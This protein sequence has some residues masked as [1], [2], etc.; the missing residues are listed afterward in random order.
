[1]ADGDWKPVLTVWSL[2]PPLP[3]GGASSGG[4]FQTSFHMPD[5]D[6]LKGRQQYPPPLMR[7]F[8]GN[9]GEWISAR[10]EPDCYSI[11]VR[12]VVGFSFSPRVDSQSPARGNGWPGCAPLS[13]WTLPVQAGLMYDKV[14][15]GPYVDDRPADF[16]PPDAPRPDTVNAYARLCAIADWPAS[17]VRLTMESRPPTDPTK[18]DAFLNW[19]S[20]AWW[21]QYRFPFRV[22]L[23]GD[24]L[25]Q[26][27][28][29]EGGRIDPRLAEGLSSLTAPRPDGALSWKDPQSVAESR[30][31]GRR[32]MP[33]LCG[34]LAPSYRPNEEF[35]SGVNL[36]ESFAINAA[37][38]SA[39]SGL[40]EPSSLKANRPGDYDR[41]G[42]A[43]ALAD[44]FW[45]A[46]NVRKGQLDD[47]DIAKPPTGDGEPNLDLDR[48][49]KSLPAMPDYPLSPA[50]R[51]VL[52]ALTSLN[53]ASANAAAEQTP[54]APAMP[55]LALFGW[56]GAAVA[57][58]ASKAALGNQQ[59]PYHYL[60]TRSFPAG[61][62]IGLEWRR[63]VSLLAPPGAV[64]GQAAA[65]V[66]MRVRQGDG[67]AEVSPNSA[68]ATYTVWIEGLTDAHA[69]HLWSRLVAGPL[70][71]QVTQ[72]QGRYGNCFLPDV[73]GQI[74]DAEAAAGGCWA[75]KLSC[76]ETLQAQE[77]GPSQAQ[78]ALPRD[79]VRRAVLFKSAL[80]PSQAAAGARPDW[81]I[82]SEPPGPGQ[83]LTA[84]AAE[85]A[86]PGLTTHSA[87]ALRRLAGAAQLLAL[88][89]GAPFDRLEFEWSG[90]GLALVGSHTLSVDL[91]PGA[92]GQAASQLVAVGAFDLLFEKEDAVVPLNIDIPDVRP[93]ITGRAF[94]VTTPPSGLRVSQLIIAGA[95][96]QDRLPDDQSL[97]LSDGVFATG[98]RLSLLDQLPAGQRSRES[99]LTLRGGSEDPEAHQPSGVS[100]TV[101]D[102]E[103]MSV[104]MVQVP[105]ITQAAAD[106]DVFATW[107][108]TERL[109]RLTERDAAWP[110]AVVL[111]LPPQ[112]TAEAWER[113]KDDV[114]N[115]SDYLP[116][117][118]ARPGARLPSRFGA[119][120]MLRVQ[121]ETRLRNPAAPWDLRRMFT[122][123]GV[124]LPGAQLLQ[125][126]QLEALYGLEA[127]DTLTPDIR[128]AELSAWRGQPPQA[129]PDQPNKAAR[130]RIDLWRTAREVWTRRLAVL[131]A[132][133]N[134]DPLARPV[135]DSAAFSLRS[136]GRYIKPSNDVADTDLPDGTWTP[137]AAGG[138]L[139]GALAGFEDRAVIMSLIGDRDKGVG[140][141]GAIDGLQLSALGA[142]TK[143]RA[144]FN[145]GL[146]VISADV[147]MG[148]THEARFERIGR[149][150]VL[151]NRAKHV[152]VY[153][154]AFLPSHQFAADQDWH[155]GRPVVRKVE[156]YIELIEPTRT[157]PDHSVATARHGGPVIGSRFRTVRIP[158][159]GSWRRP[160]DEHTGYQGYS[161]PLWRL[162]ADEAIYP[163]PVIELLIAGDPARAEPEP[164]ARRI[165]NAEDLVFYTL[166]GAATGQPAFAPTA[167][168]DIWP[169]LLGVDFANR[170]IDSPIAPGAKLAIG[171]FQNSADPA[172][173]LP[174]T[175]VVAPGL[176]AFTYRLE[177]GPSA[178]IGF[179]RGA[180]AVLSDL[181]SVTLM[182]A[183]PSAPSASTAIKITAST[184]ATLQAGRD[185]ARATLM[186]LSALA[187]A[188]PGPLTPAQLASLKAQV[189]AGLNTQLKTLT[190]GL[191][192]A[193]AAIGAAAADL[194]AST[195]K[196]ADR[197]GGAFAEVEKTLTNWIKSVQAAQASWEDGQ[198]QVVA[199]LD[200]AEQTL[201][202][203]QS[204][205]AAVVALFNA[206]LTGLINQLQDQEA[207]A[208]TVIDAVARLVATAQGVRAWR[209]TI[210]DTLTAAAAAV[211]AAPADLTPARAAL[212]AFRAQTNAMAAAAASV[213]DTCDAAV[214]ALQ[215]IAG[216][217]A[218]YSPELA[219]ELRTA[220]GSVAGPI[221]QLTSAM[222]LVVV[223]SSTLASDA[224]AALASASGLQ[225]TT[226]AVVSGALT[227]LAAKIAADPTLD[228]LCAAIDVTASAAAALPSALSDVIQDCVARISQ[229]RT[230]LNAPPSGPDPF[231]GFP[232]AVLA[233]QTRLAA[234]RVSLQPTATNP[235]PTPPP[236]QL[237]DLLAA[238]QALE[239]MVATAG[240]AIDGVRASLCTGLNTIADQATKWIK[241]APGAL[242]ALIASISAL[243]TGADIAKLLDDQLKPIDAAA[244]SLGQA[245]Y[246]ACDGPTAA[247]WLKDADPLSILRAAG[248][249]PIV[250][251]LAFN[252]DQI[253]YYFNQLTRVVT[254]PMTAFVD[255]AG[256]ELRGLGLALPTLAID[257]VLLA[258]V[259]ALFPDLTGVDFP[260]LPNAKDVIKDLAGLKDLL[261]TLDFGDL[262]QAIK[263]THDLD[264]R[265]RTAWLEA[266]LDY[267]PG[268]VDLFSYGD[269]ALHA[270]A[271]KLVGQIRYERAVAGA[272]TK[273]VHASLTADWAMILGGL[274]LV[275]I[276][277]AAAIY[278]DTTG[279]R[280]DI[281]PQNIQFD[282]ALEA[283]ADVLAA[284]AGTD[285]PVKLEMVLEDGRPV[286]LR[287][288]YDLPP[289]T[290]GA[291]VF[292]MFNASL[293]V[294]LELTQ[295]SEFEIRSFAYFGRQDRPF[296]LVVAWLGGGG[297]LE[298]EAIYRPKS[299][300]TDITVNLSLGACAGV[301]FS[302][303]P[304]GGYVQVYFGIL[305]SYSSA[306]GSR[307]TIAA[308]IVIDGSVTAWGFI[309]I[310]LGMVLTITYDNGHAVGHGHVDISVRV[311]IFCTLNYSTPINYIV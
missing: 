282:G 131:D 192:G 250:T 5:F 65:P 90:E 198:A 233:L 300:S 77:L 188:A 258:P 80:P 224:E 116:P 280:F 304:L 95:D 6:W 129:P 37:A 84:T 240:G 291:G 268:D 294:H 47:T 85:A 249:P 245:V 19:S 49:M 106:Q 57:A 256:A 28:P 208:Q 170:P 289:T 191:G 307:L 67:T 301:G 92:P 163:R 266:D 238:L 293:G 228:A 138:I 89:S 219:A 13:A 132:R 110:P 79:F 180:K 239:A 4:V 109:W 305:A 133:A 55:L 75:L 54:F 171:Q 139:G 176:E 22:P 260:A 244:Q 161:I 107:N 120:A 295:T 277:D 169:N 150:G 204:P 262:G 147:Q 30:E 164:A 40:M 99:T 223:Q 142:W 125:I 91:S 154:R 155:L 46:K 7:V 18:G 52:A 241:D 187:K 64:V 173:S 264:V 265:T 213:S 222:G 165:V 202:G 10:P 227:D 78:P 136:E 279:L 118:Q 225:A 186:G 247:A 308:L 113:R 269:F 2:S 276:K 8:A 275:R 87:E 53:P 128:L 23:L 311:S 86:F 201:S 17:F 306:G 257:D 207:R 178:N 288:L 39:Q 151:R 211:N 104:A 296:S 194:C 58:P 235:S 121:T 122:D 111:V 179:G 230:A 100:V 44:G 303:G 157:Y 267:L 259:Q 144:A 182:R 297:Y 206:P 24:V 83:A 195:T 41:W 185:Q 69:L 270:Y 66:L 217:L 143:P 43:A 251:G 73:H 59:A 97:I 181:A 160:I 254:T 190:D 20:T 226:A 287:S 15:L 137:A 229:A 218:T 290:F 96:D 175:A 76:A 286:G 271:P 172:A 61:A 216:L 284:Y 263:I 255:Q 35:L 29:T 212:A 101:L 243:P 117:D 149:I 189:T 156:E 60:Q 42:Q 16:P 93:G 102:A 45:W 81:F 174:P 162:G 115:A 234:L 285:S 98:C 9:P 38:L 214:S 135:I 200:T 127:K 31:G 261:P 197:L 32:R 51:P 114:P 1:M 145:R 126:I 112:A 199:L 94:T 26:L 82:Q 62:P 50:T 153:R 36:F 177:A 210:A 184:V 302:L 215:T 273:R 283:V 72:A 124:D 221:D 130:A 119:N 140:G 63:W 103:P 27:A 242:T 272:E 141:V 205:Q 34:G 310:G 253:G 183:D 12:D 220:A 203:L 209:K 68:D 248:A 21:L 56:T 74:T 309:T 274:Q 48:L 159:H 299:N 196:Q 71:D 246:A 70:R 193:Q 252:R 278:D 152:I 158:V 108:S 167:D 237:A 11:T 236:Q 3:G 166:T 25:G 232:G 14:G 168:T 105:S 33:I 281:K 88:D 123:L 231:A 148:R 134:A 292:S 146:S 298:A